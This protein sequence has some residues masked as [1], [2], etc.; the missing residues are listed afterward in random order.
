MLS[1]RVDL[2]D[3]K[4]QNFKLSFEFEENEF[5]GKNLVIHV[6]GSVHDGTFKKKIEV[7]AKAQKVDENSLFGLLTG[8]DS[9][10]Q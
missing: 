5:L 2:I 8:N 1:F 3:A 6:E 10:D 4:V 7:E 9:D